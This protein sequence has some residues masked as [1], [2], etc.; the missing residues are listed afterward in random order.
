MA[1]E[2]KIQWA[3]ATVNFWHGCKKVS[4]G[5]K[6]CYM[7][8]DKERYGQEPTTVVKRDFN[9]IRREIKKLKEGDLIFTCSWS[10][11]FIEEADEWRNEAWQIIKENPHLTWQILTKRPQGIPERLPADWGEGYPN[12]WLGVS[13]ESEKEITRWQYLHILPAKVKFISFEP[14]LNEITIMPSGVDWIILGGESGN[15]EGKYLYRKCELKWIEEIAGYYEKE[16]VPVFVKQLGSHLAKEL[17][18]K[19]R[20]GGDIEEF[21]EHLR[22]REFPNN[23]NKSPLSDSGVFDIKQG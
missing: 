19:D 3:T 15:N 20:F 10:D 22:I 6:Y 5:C 18:L 1:N 11:F 13:I 17:K 7:F 2:T 21:P 8:R 12:V 14:L 4:D 23:A 9:L 16:R